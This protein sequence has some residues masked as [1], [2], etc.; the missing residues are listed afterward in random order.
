MP[1]AGR[2]QAGLA[3]AAAFPESCLRVEELESCGIAIC[4]DALIAVEASG[5]DEDVI[6]SWC[7]DTTGW[8]GGG[9][10][11]ASGFD[12]GGGKAS[13]D[14]AGAPGFDDVG[15]RASGGGA[16]ASGFDNGKGCV[17]T[18]EASGRFAGASACRGGG[19]SGG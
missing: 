4:C 10:A 8:I 2:N 15:G 17:A 16:C 13:G 1:K 19:E 18:S 14:G 6:M 11:G 5:D 12:D 7:G 3:S 9:G